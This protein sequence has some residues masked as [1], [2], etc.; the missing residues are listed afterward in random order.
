MTAFFFDVGANTGQT[1]DEFLVKRSE[2]D[3][4]TVVCFEPSPRHVP[5][6]MQKAAEHG[7]RFQVVVCPFGM[8]GNSGIETFHQK[9][10][11]RGDSFERSLTSDHETKNIEV[12][13]QLHVLS[14]GIVEFISEMTAPGDTIALKLDCEGSEYE[15]LEALLRSPLALARVDPILVEWH[16]IGSPHRDRGHI[17]H[18]LIAAGKTVQPWTL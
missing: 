3:G 18:D 8:R 1:F 13:F 10:D 9:D 12:G 15:I 5:A 2:W 16:T 6:L 4:A 7:K 17:T 14:V 11:P